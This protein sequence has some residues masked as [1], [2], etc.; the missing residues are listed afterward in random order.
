MRM[1]FERATTTTT[2]GKRTALG[3]YEVA[4]L[5]GGPRRVVECVVIALAE[6]EL[7]RLRATRIHAVD[8][9]DVELPEQLVERALVMACPSSHSTASVCADLRKSPEV[10]EIGGRLADLGL[11]TRVPA[12]T[13]PGR[14]TAAPDGG[15]GREPPGLRVRRGRGPPPGHGPT[16][17]KSAVPTAARSGRS[18]SR[19]PSRFRRCVRS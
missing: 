2:A 19:P 3:L 12:P 5:A 6:R 15:G 10:A 17:L 7:V 11:V 9:V 16:R 8:A 4:Y 1:H 14:P 13:D 18:R